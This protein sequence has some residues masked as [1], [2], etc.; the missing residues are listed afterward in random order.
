MKLMS[1]SSAS[2]QEIP[3]VDDLFWLRR[4]GDLITSGTSL[5]TDAA[6]QLMSALAWIWTVYTGAAI[7]G[8]VGLRT[9]IPSTQG[10]LLALP[11]FVIVLA[12]SAAVYAYM[13]LVVSF[14]PRDPEEV[15][16]AYSNAARRGW[17]R[18]QVALVL[19]GLA[20]ISIG[21]AVAVVASRS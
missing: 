17:R 19:S 21:L 12:Y 1:E 8:A 20:A 16:L 2:G 15:R 13:P 5:R 18:L 14:E 4:A 9:R 7:L 6:R 3:L 11:S 10:W